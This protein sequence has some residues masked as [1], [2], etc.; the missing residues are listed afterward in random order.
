MKNALRAAGIFALKPG[1]PLTRQLGGKI[2]FEQYY[3]NEVALFGTDSLE[4]DPFAVTLGVKYQPVPLIV[5]GTDFK[6]GTGDNTDLSVNATLNY[7][8]GVRSKTSLILTK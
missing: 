6:A 8:F 3:G 5:V 1:Y 4:K 7:Q 2:V